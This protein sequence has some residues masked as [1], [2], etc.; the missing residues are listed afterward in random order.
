M[1]NSI[2]FF[3]EKYKPILVLIL[4]IFTIQSCKVY[5]NPTTLNETVKDTSKGYV[6]VT[7]LNGDEYIYEDIVLSDNEYLGIKTENNTK[8]KTIL[9]EEEI[10]NVQRVNKNSSNFFGIF[11]IIVGVGS[12]ILG[13]GML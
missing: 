7:M 12:I 9:K 5:Q 4:V 10:L 2:S 1:K 6:K 13:I 3:G 8:V 11:G